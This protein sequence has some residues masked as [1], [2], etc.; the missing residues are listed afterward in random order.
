MVSVESIS[1]DS[2]KFEAM[3]DVQEPTSLKELVRF[4]GEL[5]W[6]SRYFRSLS[7]MCEPLSHL[8]KKDI[9]FVWS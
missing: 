9:E 4:V 3:Q 1:I 2:K 8:T 5:K 7:D 6:H